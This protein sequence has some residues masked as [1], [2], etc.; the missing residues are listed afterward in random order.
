MTAWYIDSI[1]PR[2]GYAFVTHRPP[3]LYGEDAAALDLQTLFLSPPFFQLEAGPTRAVALAAARGSF[4]VGLI[5]EGQET[6]F[7]SLED[8]REYVR[9]V[10]LCSA[11]GDGGGGGGDAGERGEPMGSPLPPTP[12]GLDGLGEANRSQL[13]K[14]FDAISGFRH[15]SETLKIGNLGTTFDWHA[16]FQSLNLPKLAPQI[17]LSGSAALAYEQLRRLPLDGGDA[18]LL[19]WLEQAKAVGVLIDRLGLTAPVA[20]ILTSVREVQ[21]LLEKFTH[22]RNLEEKRYDYERYFWLLCGLFSGFADFRWYKMLF[23][24]WVAYA[25]HMRSVAQ[26]FDH[27]EI[28]RRIV[29]P[30]DVA[31]WLVTFLESQH[32]DLTLQQLL[33]VVLAS[34]PLLE[35]VG[36]SSK[37]TAAITLVLLASVHLA[38]A[39]SSGTPFGTP[40]EDSPAKP[41]PQPII[42]HL[43][44]A[45]L[46]RAL[47]A[48]IFWIAAALPRRAL[49]EPLERDIVGA[50]RLR[51]SAVEATSAAS[52]GAIV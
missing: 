39:A 1:D 12:R 6:P 13:S 3:D 9:R 43:H 11:G 14:L 34:P 41:D 16:R 44:A 7:R 28:L 31:G 40:E 52:S 38:T 49:P 32:P 29:L 36:E 20:Q 17:L 50:M 24:G 26:T 46:G 35:K 37:F 10:Y 8:I 51:Y 4:Q 45:A 27:A 25:S 21:E 33:M 48:G 2:G 47:E 18:S 42:P 23:L 30:H 19:L 5:H 15:S 22:S